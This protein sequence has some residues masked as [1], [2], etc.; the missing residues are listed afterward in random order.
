M[1][2]LPVTTSMGELLFYI[3]EKRGL[4]PAEVELAETAAGKKLLSMKGAIADLKRKDIYV[5]ERRGRK[6]DKRHKSPGRLGSRSPRRRGATTPTKGVEAD[7]HRVISL[8]AEGVDLNDVRMP[9]KWTEL[10]RRAGLESII[11]K[12]TTGR[13]AIF[14]II[15]Q[16]GGVT[17]LLQYDDE[18]LRRIFATATNFRRAKTI[19]RTAKAPKS[20][21]ITK[22]T[23]ASVV[24]D[25]AVK[26]IDSSSALAFTSG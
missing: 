20:G 14:D 13:S 11:T 19:K 4:D 16:R 1:V 21:A 23:A 18:Y 8:L 12:D 2:K 15:E 9:I 25:S 26:S 7:K 24:E 17:E 6:K 3:C 10:F 5:V 22:S